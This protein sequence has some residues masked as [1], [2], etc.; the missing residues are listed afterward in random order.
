M[1]GPQARVL[2]RGLRCR[3]VLGIRRRVLLPCGVFSGFKLLGHP[4][5]LIV[6]DAWSSQVFVAGRAMS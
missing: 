4:P 1:Q 2:G 5:A 6:T 3:V